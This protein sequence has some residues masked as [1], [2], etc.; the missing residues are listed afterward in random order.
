[1]ET[2][3]LR[4]EVGVNKSALRTMAILNYMAAVRSPVGI[5]EMSRALRIPKS[6]V[7]SL[8]NTLVDGRYIELAGR[9]HKTYRLGFK[10]FQ[11]GIT[12]LSNVELHQVAHPLLR[13][14]MVTLGQTVH[15]GTEDEEELVFLDSI[16]AEG[17]VVRSAARL[18]RSQ[19]PM[20][21][22]GL[23]KALLA[24][25]PD[26]ELVRRF[27]GARFEART[28][29]TIEDINQLMDEMRATRRRGYAVDDGE[30]SIDLF[31]VAA[32]LYDRSRAVVGAISCSTPAREKANE[33]RF[34]EAV[35][36]AAVEI[37]ERLGFLGSRFY[38]EF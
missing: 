29:N 31:C 32:P 33:A 25:H 10:L 7:F 17:S 28:A 16:E 8:V 35:K 38:G 22:S 30:S 34:A 1:M 23:G 12:Y 18:G 15:L 21:C 6:S 26:E 4:S 11:T 14:L 20:Y 5:S 37:S 27:R 36:Q 2:K 19:S 13:E 24:A 3:T 9:E